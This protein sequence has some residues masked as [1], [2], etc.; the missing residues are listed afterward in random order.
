MR[1]ATARFARAAAVLALAA[2]AAGCAPG[3][4]GVRRYGSVIEVKAEKLDYYRQLHANAWPGVLKM[5]KEC[6]IQ[7]YSIY[8]TQFPDGRWYLF[9]YFEYAGDDFEADMARMAADPTTKQW[10]KETDPCQAPL[11]NRKEGERW[12]TM[13]EVFHCP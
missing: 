13:D 11:A 9:G 10:W 6:H 7:N 4:A 1:T 3:A 2:L 8:L 12:K 5:I